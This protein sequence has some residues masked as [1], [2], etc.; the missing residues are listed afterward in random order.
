MTSPQRTRRA[1]KKARRSQQGAA[2]LIVLFILMMA[3]GTAVYSLQST[4]F[5]QRAA[6]SLQQAMR[7][8]FVAE[9]AT[10]SLLAFCYQGGVAG[11]TDLKRSELNFDE[12]DEYAL[13]DWGGV[14]TIYELGPAD[15]T[16]SNFPQPVVPRDSQISGG[17]MASVYTPDFVSVV[18]RWEVPNP[19]ETRQRYRLIVSTYGL[20]GILSDVRGTD[21]LRD[22]HASVSSTRAFFDVR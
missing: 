21:E 20:L 12:R 13:P 4:Q 17:G 14:D 19:G 1:A 22:A 15:L 16:G 7:T 9:A 11:C 8:K 6:G 2:L 3:T 5:E 10:V 18:E